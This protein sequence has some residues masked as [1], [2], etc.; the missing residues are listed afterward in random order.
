MVFN[1]GHCV[2]NDKAVQRL[3]SALS[4]C[5]ATPQY[6]IETSKIAVSQRSRDELSDPI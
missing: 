6:T 3:K 1:P 5:V 4:N 2:I